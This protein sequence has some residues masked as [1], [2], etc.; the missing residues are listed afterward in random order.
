MTFQICFD[1]VSILLQCVDMMRDVHKG[2]AAATRPPPLNGCWR[3]FD[4]DICCGWTLV[5]HVELN[6]SMPA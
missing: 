4:Y 1:G 2:E 3:M 6:A 5:H